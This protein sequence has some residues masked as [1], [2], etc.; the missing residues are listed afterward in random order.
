MP[1]F[2]YPCHRYFAVGV[3]A[4]S[5][6]LVVV[7]EFACE[8]ISAFMCYALEPRNVDV[9]PCLRGYPRVVPV[10]RLVCV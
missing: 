6:G 5:N 1:V 2:V 9:V 10:H 4:V 8:V 3:V 7:V